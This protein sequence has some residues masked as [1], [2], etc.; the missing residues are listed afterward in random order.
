M[1]QVL[2]TRQIC[3]MSHNISPVFHRACG[4]ANHWQPGGVC[5]QGSTNLVSG[6]GAKVWQDFQGMQQPGQGNALSRTSLQKC[7]VSFSSH[8]QLQMKTPDNMIQIAVQQPKLCVHCFPRHKMLHPCI[9][10]PYS[11][12]QQFDQALAC[13]ALSTVL[14]WR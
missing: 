6:A 5:P 3:F 11:I 13:A 10:R 12:S 14:V 1:S 4:M 8:D 7:A 9:R 2:Q